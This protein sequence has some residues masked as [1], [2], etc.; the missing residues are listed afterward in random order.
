MRE[1]LE[2]LARLPDRHQRA[3]QWFIDR[4]GTEHPWPGPLPD[5][6]ILATRAKGIY[7]PA[8]TQYALS[9]RQ[10][11]GAHYPDRTPIHRSDGAWLYRYFQEGTDPA[12][13][14]DYFTNV[15]MNA[16]TKDRVPVGVML[17]TSGRPHVKYRIMGVALVEGW[18]NGFYILRGAS[19]SPLG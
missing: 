10:V 18:E 6:T 8:W 15:A 17:Q 13:R 2:Q 16:C 19:R 12:Q 14:D 4:A 9:I 5:G 1:D 7:K 11:I 3:L